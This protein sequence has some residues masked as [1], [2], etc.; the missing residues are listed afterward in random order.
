MLQLLQIDVFTYWNLLQS[1][2]HHPPTCLAFS[3]VIHSLSSILMYYGRMNICIMGCHRLCMYGDRTCA[4]WQYGASKYSLTWKLKNAVK[5]KKGGGGDA[6]LQPLIMTYVFW[7]FFSM[8]KV[9]VSI[10]NGSDSSS[11]RFPVLTNHMK[12]CKENTFFF[13]SFSTKLEV[14]SH[15]RFCSCTCLITK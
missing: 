6:I 10:K 12:T 8:C 7:F 3:F 1:G 11:P 14:C 2:K 9:I 15:I 5:K 13:S 4:A